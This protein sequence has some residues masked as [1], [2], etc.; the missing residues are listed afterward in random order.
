MD[1]P[2]TGLTRFGEQV[3][4][5]LEDATRPAEQLRLVRPRLL[6]HATHGRATTRRRALQ[7]WRYVGVA[8]ALAV[9]G[10]ALLAW[11]APISFQAGSLEGR[12]GDVLAATEREPLR[13][14]FSE[15]SRMLL[16]RSAAARVLETRAAGARV[17]LERG[18]ADVSIAHRTGRA[19]RWRFEAGP[20][21]ILVTGTQ[22]EFAWQPVQQ[23][24]SLI[25]KTGSVEVSGACLAQPRRV[26]GGASLR[27]SCAQVEPTADSTIV[28]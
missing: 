20:F 17:L 18:V 6:Q 4:E 3:Q 8:A 15:G 25:M 13:V 1:S 5:A 16:H 24:L 14:E 26:E 23:A 12:A 28:A 10:A 22:F 19:T 11:Y 7:R 2:K 27:L 21:Q 9:V